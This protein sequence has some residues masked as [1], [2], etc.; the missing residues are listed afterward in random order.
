MSHNQKTGTCCPEVDTSRWDKQIHEWKDK[1][2]IKGSIPL[3]YH[4]PLPGKV[5]KVITRLWDQA[6]AGGDTTEEKDW[7]LLANDPSPWKGEYLLAVSKEIPGARNVKLTGTFF[8]QVFDG[9]YSGAPRYI[10]QMNKELQEQNKKAKEYY[11]YYTTCPKCAKKYGH[12]YIV[13][14]AEV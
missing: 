6:Q 9:P 14:F 3:C 11:F 1:I 13:G 12:N 5:K 10:K 2:F 7:L 4:M 8:S